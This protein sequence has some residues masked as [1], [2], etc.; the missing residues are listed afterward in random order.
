MT[1]S[2]KQK[3]MKAL[4]AKAK[5]MQAQLGY[6]HLQAKAIRK[7]QEA[8]ETLLQAGEAEFAALQRAEVEPEPAP[9]PAEA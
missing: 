5:D 8:V 4:Q 3:Q 7:E 2:E 9:E 6:L 1:Q